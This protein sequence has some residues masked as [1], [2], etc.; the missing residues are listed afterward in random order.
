MEWEHPG[1]NGTEPRGWIPKGDSL[2]SLILPSSVYPQSVCLSVFIK[3]CKFHPPLASSLPTPCSVAPSPSSPP[4][5]LAASKINFQLEQQVPR[6][7]GPLAASTGCKQLSL[8]PLSQPLNFSAIPSLVFPPLSSLKGEGRVE[9][10]PSH[11]S[12]EGSPSPAPSILPVSPYVGFQG[13][14]RAGPA[15]RQ[16]PRPL[17]Y[18]R[19]RKDALIGRKSMEWGPV[20]PRQV[21]GGAQST[22]RPRWK[23]RDVSLVIT[24]ERLVRCSL[25]GGE[26]GKAETSFSSSRFTEGPGPPEAPGRTTLRSRE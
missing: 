8:H 23:L 2:S 4:P 22:P 14:S 26:K 17:P 11:S 20:E 13:P 15:V 25:F 16:K 9:S 3:A 21:R 7:L 10:R 18:L 6:H 19:G 5:S 12:S 24:P 1:G